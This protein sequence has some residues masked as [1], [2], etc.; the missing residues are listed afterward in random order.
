MVAPLC[1]L[2]SLGG[3]HDRSTTR[4]WTKLFHR[5]KWAPSR[6]QQTSRKKFGIRAAGRS[7]KGGY[8]LTNEDRC[9][10]DID[11]RVFLVADGIGGHVGGE[12]AAEIAVSTMPTVLNHALDAENAD[13][14]SMQEAVEKAVAAARQE[15]VEYADLHSNCRRMGTTVAMAAIKDDKLYFSHIGDSRV[16]LARNGTIRR[17][18]SDHSFVQ[19]LVDAGVINEE[20][21]RTHPQRHCV[22][23]HVGVRQL[24]HP[25]RVASLR[26]K[27]GD[28]VVLATDGLTGVVD[29]HAIEKIVTHYDDTH[30]AADALIRE[31]MRK[32]SKDNVTCV[33]VQVL[34]SYERVVE[35]DCVDYDCD[36]CAAY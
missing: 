35:K 22:L 2:D 8:R 3:K 13:V 10:V 31:A 36:S 20:D 12:R 34:K 17:L 1:P 6:T 7:V 33:I 14:N 23:N 26:L 9:Y 18:T 21:A 24:D 25:P 27:T 16:Y 30:D 15:M 11:G 5:L 4:Y 32:D 19:V 29:D 28:V